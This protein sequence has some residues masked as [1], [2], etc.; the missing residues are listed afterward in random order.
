MQDADQSHECAECMSRFLRLMYTYVITYEYPLQVAPNTYKMRVKTNWCFEFGNTHRMNI[1]CANVFTNHG[2]LHEHIHS[3]F[4]TTCL[5]S[6][7]IYKIK[8][9]VSITSQSWNMLKVLCFTTPHS[10]PPSYIYTSAT[11]PLGTP[12]RVWSIVWLPEDLTACL[13]SLLRGPQ[14]IT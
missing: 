9:K 10:G 11:V 3:Y 12:G 2:T 7:K 14:P 6:Y 1:T 8:P 5:K 4:L 13:S